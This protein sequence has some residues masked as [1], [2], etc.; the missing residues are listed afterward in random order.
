MLQSWNLSAWHE[1]FRSALELD[2][3]LHRGGPENRVDRTLHVFDEGRVQA[4]ELKGIPFVVGPLNLTQKQHSRTARAR[5]ILPRQVRVTCGAVLCVPVPRNRG[6]LLGG[7]FG[8]LPV[9]RQAGKFRLAWQAE[10]SVDQN[11][12]YGRKM[13]S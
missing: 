1:A 10:G 11:R 7:R 6:V 4:L 3:G 8:A 5:Q 2:A 9:S 12:V 13:S